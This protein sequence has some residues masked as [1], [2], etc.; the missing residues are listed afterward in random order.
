MP[1][2]IL[3]ALST[4]NPAAGG[5]VEG[6]HQL[7]RR[8]VLLGHHIEFL[9]LDAPGEP[10]LK[11]ILVPVHAVGPTTLGI[12][13][14]SPRYVSWLRVHA[15]NFDCVIVNGIWNFNGYGTWLALRNTDIP[16]F[17]FTHGMLDPWFKHR[18]PFKHLKKLL[19]WPWGGYPMLR[20]AHAV[21]FTCEEERVLA[22]ESFWLYDC[23]E[24]VL[25]Y[26]TDGL[27][28]PADNHPKDAFLAAHPS[29]RGKRLFTFL[30]R[31]HPKKGPDL[32][33]KAVATLIERK[34]WDARTMCVVMAGPV[35]GAYAATLRRLIKKL[36]LEEIVYWTDML[37]GQQKWGVL[38]ASEVMALPSHQENFGL[39]V[40]ESLSTGTPVLLGKGV[41]IWRDIVEDGAGFAGD[42]TVAGCVEMLT[43][44][45]TLSADKQDAMRLRARSCYEARYM[46]ESAANTFV[47]ALYLL[48]SVHK[49][50][51][52][53]TNPKRSD[54][55][56]RL[57]EGSLPD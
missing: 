25:R 54:G 52:W 41:N 15:H 24:F 33:I 5:P 22:R 37:L 31:V 27:P 50:Q 49:G 42:D 47:A 20:D 29:L 32:L 19:Y 13:G 2:R 14:Y 39:V 28:W 43:R 44:W 26:G 6:V 30:G 4:L 40:A 1:L 21:F 18:Y 23:H 7:T 35:S 11:R 53:K 9:T 12:Y 34:I 57:P 38:Q 36:G 46:A 45:I 55:D 3:H 17:V 8:N 16:Y 56:G 10:W 51:R 48:L